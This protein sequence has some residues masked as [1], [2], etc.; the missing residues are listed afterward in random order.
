MIWSPL[1]LAAWPRREH[2]F[3]YRND[4]PC[5]FSLTRP[6]D[7]TERY[8]RAK[9]GGRRFAPM[10]FWAVAAVCNRHAE[11]RMALRGGA[12]GV[13]DRVDPVYTVFHAQTETF[14]TIWT[15]YDEDPDRFAA[16]CRAD[17]QAYGENLAF[18]AKPDCP[19]NAVNVSMLPWANFTSFQLNLPP[20]D[21]LL[22]IFTF[23]RAERGADGRVRLPVS[24]QAHHAAMDGFHVCRVLD[25][26]EALL[27]TL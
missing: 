6:L 3:H 22:P 25:E 13:Y 17:A 14:S 11:C 15:E 5:G 24:V 23:G 10:I 27:G 18:A 16:R 7:V 1:D 21:Y 9:A 2:F 26:L 8:A 4:V 12:P 19:E 20:G